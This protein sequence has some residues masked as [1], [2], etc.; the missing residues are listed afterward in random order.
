MFADDSNLF[1]SAKNPYTIVNTVNN[2]LKKISKWLEVNRLSLNLSKTSYMIF[3]QTN[4]YKDVNL[5]IRMSGEKVTRVDKT[6]FLGLIIDEKVSWQYHIGNI[7]T[8]V[9]K[10][11]GIITRARRTFDKNILMT[12]YHTMIQPY[13]FYCHLIWGTTYKTYLDQLEKLQKRAVRTICNLRKYDH[14][15]KHF[16]ELKII[17]LADLYQYLLIIFMYQYEKLNL[18]EVFNRYFSKNRTGNGAR[19][20]TRN[21]DKYRMPRYDT[22]LGR[23]FVRKQGVIVGNKYHKVIS[24]CET[25]AA[26]KNIFKKSLFESYHNVT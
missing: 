16:K 12:L 6:K 15:E 23:A 26:C 13:L 21:I 7:S 8:K 5:D 11:L 3:Q 9:A 19:P 4:K 10:S 14:T 18:P 24:E 17:K 22:R 2:E 25:I 1:A 20:I